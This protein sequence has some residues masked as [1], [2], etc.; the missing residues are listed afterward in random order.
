MEKVNESVSSAS[1][2]SQSDS[3][4]ES[5]LSFLRATASMSMSVDA[6]IKCLETP[7]ASFESDQCM[8][9]NLDQQML[10]QLRTQVD[11]QAEFNLLANYLGLPSSISAAS[12]MVAPQS[13]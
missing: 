1:A 12:I 9:L 13:L 2:E 10:D 8:Q 3:L 4:I 5:Q 11:D 7:I 6:L